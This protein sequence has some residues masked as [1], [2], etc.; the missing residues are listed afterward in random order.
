LPGTTTRSR[1]GA[2]A[3]FMS[4]RREEKNTV[5]PSTS[6]SPGAK[7]F[8]FF[9]LERFGL[10]LIVLLV[11]GTFTVLAQGFLS[12]F[13]LFTLSRET[14]V[15]VMIGLSQ[16]VVLGVGQMNLAVGA[17]G[18]MSAMCTGAAMEALGFPPPIAV[19][20]GLALGVLTGWFNGFLVVRTG[21]NS[22]IVTLA[23]AS[24]Y[25]GLMLITTKAKAFSNLPESFVMLGQAGSGIFSLLLLITV[26]MA[27]TLAYLYW[28]SSLGRKMLAA[29]ANPRAA[30]LSGVPVGW[31][32]LFAH[33][34]SGFLAGLAG[35]ML[36]SNL[37]SAIPSIGVDWVLPSFVAPIIGG[38]LLSGGV[39]SVFG[40]FLGGLL[41]VGISNGLQLMEVNNFWV[42]LFQGVVLL[43]AVVLDRLR[44]LR[45]E[46][47]RLPT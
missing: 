5:T 3:E 43:A 9:S 28:G 12:T 15:F 20:F 38:T 41:V 18:V 13:N 30:A 4:E 34:M 2:A 47:M 25:T 1:T 44:V 24:V 42:Q 29:G 39:V 14:A 26:A 23:M 46:K 10:L 31:M 19:V 17:I 27:L 16:M 8:S 36:A 33:S 37:G 35:I 45:A 6:P 40:T 32:V 11:W 7:L 22:F 21:V